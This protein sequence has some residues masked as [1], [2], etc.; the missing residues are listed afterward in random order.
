MRR[1]LLLGMAVLASGCKPV[2]KA[3]G[4][5]PARDLCQLEREATDVVLADVLSWGEPSTRRLQGRRYR[6]TPVKLR[7]RTAFKGG[8]FGEQTAWFLGDV[9]PAGQSAYGPLRGATA[10]LYL[11]DVDPDLVLVGGGYLWRSSPGHLKNAKRYAEGEGVEEKIIRRELDAAARG[12]SS[13]ESAPGP[14]L[15]GH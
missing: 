3:P 1:L 9:D 5:Y 11:K 12:A 15:L 4:E 14:G 2:V 6:V 7:V 10:I 8:H 13:C